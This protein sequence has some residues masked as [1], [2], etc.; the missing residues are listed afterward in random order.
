MKYIQ[1]IEEC[2]A[3]DGI[4]KLTA[5]CEIDLIQ[6]GKSTTNW[7]VPNTHGGLAGAFTWSATPQENMFWYNIFEA[8]GEK[9]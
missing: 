8:I 3:L 6:Q 1:Q 4:T 9:W 2:E 7:N 5:L